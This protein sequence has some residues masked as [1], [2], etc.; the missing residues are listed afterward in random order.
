[1]QSWAR[2]QRERVCSP[3]LSSVAA[4]VTG[5]PCVRQSGSSSSSARGSSTLPDRMCAPGHGGKQRC[6]AGHASAGPLCS[7]KLMQRQA[8]AVVQ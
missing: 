2:V 5:A 3:R 4:V 6:Q 8:V 1:M 7:S